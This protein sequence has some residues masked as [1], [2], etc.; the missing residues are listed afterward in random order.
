MTD[1]E[2][3]VRDLA[4]QIWEEDGRPEGA[5]ARHWSEAERRYAA[6]LGSAPPPNGGAVA[7]AKAKPVKAPKAKAVAAAAGTPPKAGGE[8]GKIAAAAA[9]PKRGKAGGGKPSDAKRAADAPKADKSAGA[10]PSKK[11]KG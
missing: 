4:Y 8:P 7:G 5:G 11:S 2:R 3:R 6:E 9:E 10:K 1:R